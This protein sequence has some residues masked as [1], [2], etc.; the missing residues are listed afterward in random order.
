MYSPFSGAVLT[1][2]YELPEGVGRDR[3]GVMSTETGLLPHRPPVEEPERGTRVV[4]LDTT[5]ASELCGVLASE[6]A[7]N[8]LAALNEEPMVASGVADRVETSLQ[9]AHHH[10]GRL[11]EVDLVHVVDTWYSSRGSEM[12]VYAPVDERLV[13][14]APDVGNAPDPSPE[15]VPVVATQR[16]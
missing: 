14:A 13:I 11:R 1:C 2:V 8:V 7:T 12:K 3:R 9:N 10:L 6:T 16:N 15:D 4:E 5:E